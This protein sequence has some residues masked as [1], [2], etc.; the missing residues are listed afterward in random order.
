[1][2]ASR[3]LFLSGAIFNLAVGG[4]LLFLFSV[5][6]PFLGIAHVPPDLTFLVD[7]VGL[8][9]CAFGIAYWLVSVD[10]PRYR[11]FAVFGAACKVMVFLVIAAHFV[12]GRVGWQLFGLG[13]VDLIYAVLFWMVIRRTTRSAVAQAA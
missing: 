9:V 8:F 7:I 2:I 10:F 13:I 3:A 4:G 5:L 11:L 12:L 1:M 6:Q